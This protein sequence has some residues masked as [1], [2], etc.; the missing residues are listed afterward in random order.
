[1]LAGIIFLVEVI[2]KYKEIIKSVQ[3]T[4]QLYFNDNE[5][6]T[7]SL[8]EKRTDPRTTSGIRYLRLRY[9]RWCTFQSPPS[10]DEYGLH[11]L[12]TQLLFC[13][14]RGVLFWSENENQ[15]LY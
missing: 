1:M 14:K 11:H 9:W 4:T 15:I 12:T 3:S 5:K 6:L 13:I 7:A 8:R 2:V 10:L